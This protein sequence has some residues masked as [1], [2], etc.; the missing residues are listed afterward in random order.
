MTHLKN[1][2]DSATINVGKRKV[3]ISAGDELYR[4]SFDPAFARSFL[5]LLLEQSSADAAAPVLR[6][7]LSLV[8][9]AGSERVSGERALTLDRQHR[10]EMASINTSLS[11]LASC[12]AALL[13]PTAHM[14]RTGTRC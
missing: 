4:Q 5:Q 13:S 6:A 2:L 10:R 9:L 3:L 14:C 11:A 1:F 12:I 8:D 7:R